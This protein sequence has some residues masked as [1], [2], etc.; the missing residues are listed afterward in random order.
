MTPDDRAQIPEG[1]KQPSATWTDPVTGVQQ[2]GFGIKDCGIPFGDKTFI[3][4]S[5]DESAVPICKDIHRLIEGISEISSHAA[6]SMANYSCM[7]R[8]NFLAGSTPS[9]LTK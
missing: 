6:F 7:H 9:K 8:A 4:A 3:L 2:V 1:I 5:L